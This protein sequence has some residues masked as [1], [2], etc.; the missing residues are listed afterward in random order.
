MLLLLLLLVVDRTLRTGSTGK[1][2][3]PY[4]ASTS[5]NGAMHLA[6]ETDDLWWYMLQYVG[7]T[8]FSLSN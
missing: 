7:E 4:P 1:P 5:T 8:E 6:A 3:Y 2:P